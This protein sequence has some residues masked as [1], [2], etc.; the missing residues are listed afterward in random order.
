MMMI[1]EADQ[2]C[3]DCRHMA[4]EHDTIVGCR[5]GYIEH[6]ERFECVCSHFTD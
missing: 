4:G 6:G 1:V 3:N 2:R 5:H